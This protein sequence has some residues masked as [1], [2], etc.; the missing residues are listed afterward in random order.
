MKKYLV[1]YTQGTW[2]IF[3]IGHLNLI[4]RAKEQCET[5]IVGVN[6]DR[7]VESYKHKIPYYSERDRFAI[8]KNL[9]SVD[10]CFV[11][12]TLDKL[13]ILQQIQFNAIFIG[14]DWLGNQRWMSTVKCM[15]DY[16]IDVIFLPHTEGISSSYLRSVNDE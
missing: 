4:N 7:L 14:D 15:A 2:D 9:K 1:G 6:S 12:D 11:V 5:L 16:G 8:I 13:E 3:H 10:D